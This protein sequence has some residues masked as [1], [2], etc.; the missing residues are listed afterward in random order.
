MNPLYEESGNSG[1]NPMYDPSLRA[2]PGNPIGGIIVKGGKNPGGQMI[3]VISDNNGEVILNGLEK[4]NYL[5]KLNQP[6]RPAE[7]GINEAGIKFNDESAQ[8]PGTPVGGIVV[9]GGKNPGGSFIILNISRSGQIGFEVLEAG[10]Y[11]LI[12][13]NPVDTKKIRAKNTKKSGKKVKEKTSSGLKDT[14]K[15]NV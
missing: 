3:T 8:R 9:K 7:K 1:I 4:G 6:E 12:L 10:N 2:K 14:L 5:F 13:T 11:K 15:T